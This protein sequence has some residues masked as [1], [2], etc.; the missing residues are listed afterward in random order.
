M[1][2]NVLPF[3]R[4]RRH[5]PDGKGEIN[6]A[7]RAGTIR[8]RGQSWQALLSFTDPDTKRPVQFSKT[9]K[10]KAEAEAALA[11]LMVKRDAHKLVRNHESFA[12]LA[13]RWVAHCE[14]S[15]DY[16]RNTMDAYRRFARPDGRIL[17]AL[18]ALKCRDVTTRHIDEYM[19]TLSHLATNTR[20]S[21]LVALSSMCHLAVNWGW[22]DENPVSKARWP[23]KPN[24]TTKLPDPEGAGRLLEACEIDGPFGMTMVRFAMSTGCRHGEIAGLQWG[25]I[26]W[27]ERRVHIQRQ[28]SGKGYV[29]G[30]KGSKPGRTKDRW[31]SLGAD[32]IAQMKLWR[33][34]QEAVWAELCGGQVLKPTDYVFAAKATSTPGSV[35]A[36][37]SHHWQ[38]VRAY[39]ALPTMRL[40]DCRHFV[41]TKLLS[42][43][44]PPQVVAKILGHADATTTLRTYAHVLDGD[45]ET[46]AEVMDDVLREM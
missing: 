36:R 42:K 43:K 18:G 23:Q 46:A 11:E 35:Y 26:E 33:E 13:E 29:Q 2:L 44:L 40:H 19:G 7:N 22:M 10:T 25:D 41:A 15:G 9:T 24:T 31:V 16:S 21:E 3:D 14:S 30:P 17:Q 27:D 12:Q 38:L 4:P 39:A 37:V 34:E 8:K 32:A 6:M 20:V 28:V 45:A 5:C 1:T